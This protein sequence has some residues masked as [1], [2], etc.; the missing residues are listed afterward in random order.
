MAAR[1]AGALRVVF[2][3][4]AGMFLAEFTAGLLI[5]STALLG[6]SLDMLGDALVYGFSLYALGRSLRWRNG[7]ALLKGLGMAGFGLAVLAHALFQLAHGAAPAGGPM[8]AVAALAMAANAICFALLYRHR[9]DL[10]MRS[11]WLC[12][13]NDLI[14]NAGVLLAAAGVH[15]TGSSWPD[16]LVGI[17][18]AGLFLATAAGVLKASADAL[19]RPE[20]RKA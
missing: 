15:A 10:N 2:G 3:I 12:S 9:A 6:D 5:G 16:I 11:T 19:M 17:A 4:N 20:V 18:I 13:R 7:A 14:A 8:A 1:R